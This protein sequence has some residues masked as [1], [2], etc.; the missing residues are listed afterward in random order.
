M[1]RRGEIEA[2][3]GCGLVFY[4]SAETYWRPR[5]KRK[6]RRVAQNKSGS[7]GTAT[8]VVRGAAQ[9]LC[10]AITTFAPFFTPR[11]CPRCEWWRGAGLYDEGA[12]ER[13]SKRAWH[14]LRLRPAV[15][16]LSPF[17]GRA[18]EER[19]CATRFT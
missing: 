17:P 19:A 3:V 12:D 16:L 1:G 7:R 8:L 9:N 11:S 5:G 6:K 10:H 15:A 18:L 4:L 14:R 13:R 2:G